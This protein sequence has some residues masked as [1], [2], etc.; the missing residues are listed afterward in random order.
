[1]IPSLNSIKN[2]TKIELLNPEKLQG[3]K[4]TLFMKR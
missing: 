1:M 2:A 4:Y 3:S